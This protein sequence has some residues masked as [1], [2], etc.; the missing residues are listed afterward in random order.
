MTVATPIADVAAT[1]PTPV[2]SPAII[3]I[4]RR[5]PTVIPSDK[6][7]VIHM[8][9]VTETRKNVGTKA[10]NKETFRNDIKRLVTVQVADCAQNCTKIH[11]SASGQSITPDHA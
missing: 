2:N 6:A 11:L 9:G 3:H 7:R 1:I 8:P 4:A 5:T 10:D